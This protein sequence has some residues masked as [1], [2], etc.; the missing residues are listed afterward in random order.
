M[1]S[2]FF[3]SGKTGCGN[4][5][6]FGKQ[7]KEQRQLTVTGP[8]LASMALLIKVHKKN[9]PGRAYV[10]QID[11]PSYKL[12]KELTEILNPIDE[13]GESF[14]RDTY[15]FKEMLDAVKIEEGCI[16]GTLDIIGMF[17]NVPVQKTLEVVREK[18]ETD[19]SLKSRTKW[20]VKDIMKLLEISV[21]TYFKTID[22][23]IYFQRDG[24]PIGKS[25]SK[26]LAGIYMHWFEETHIF[27]EDGEFSNNIV[28]WKRQMDDIFFVWKGSKEEL[29]LF[30]WKLNGIEN[31]IQFT[32]Q[33]EEGG[34]LPFLDVGITKLNGSMVTKI[35]RKPT[36]TQQYI[37]WN[38]NH[39]KN[40]LLGV[41][42]GLIHRAHMLCDLKEDLLEELDLL[43]NVF[44]SN[45]YP[46]KLVS[47]TI[48]ES[49]P[50]ETLK[51]V[52]KG[53]QQDVE[54][55]NPKDYFEVLHA[56]YV[57]GFS[58]GLQRRLRRLG[59]GFV[60]KKKETFY[61]NLCRLKCR[62]SFEERKD[63]IYSIPCKTCGIRYI[64]E[65]GQHFCDRRSQHQRDVRNRKKTNGFYAHLDKNEGHE[66]DWENASFIDSEKF[67]K[68]RKVKESLY[69]S[70]QNPSKV[71]DAKVILNLEKGLELDPMWG[72][73]NEQFRRTMEEKIPM[74]AKL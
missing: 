26:P 56:P 20:E 7:F 31:R 1:H 14:I 17:P 25:I 8:V 15:H 62:V 39:P 66:L 3:S 71:V 42:K 34:F 33:V 9:F 30:V 21:E 49:W 43:K 50:R 10:S 65:T 53:V 11:D 16:I 68:G 13:K 52:L 24:L 18:L 46:E 74:G 55:E 67:W 36:H 27:K 61:T 54:V 41:L 12:C 59:I 35:Y 2:Q 4:P 38:S 29:E 70:A 69:I 48:T 40:M 37:H 5:A 45:G 32:L 44:I 60:P 22:G 47:K 6:T 73:F 28:F 51:A 64:G 58:E 72:F 57:K 19:D 23:K 63:V